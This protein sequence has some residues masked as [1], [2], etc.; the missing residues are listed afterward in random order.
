MNQK[1]LSNLKKWPKGTSGNPAGRKA[2]SKNMA[3]LA[4]EL[5]DQ[6]VDEKLPINEP[7]SELITES[8]TYAKAVVLAMAVKAINGD[9]RAATYLTE[10]QHVDEMESLEP[11]LFQTDKLEIT[12]VDS[13]HSAMDKQR[14]LQV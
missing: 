3:T 8:T 5:L 9:V 1:S 6:V 2:G 13:K 12:I 14:L 7:I 4:R 10:L 11:G